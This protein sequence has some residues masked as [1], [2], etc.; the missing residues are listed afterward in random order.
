MRSLV[1]RGA[2]PNYLEGGSVP[3]LIWA[4][5]ADNVVG[6]KALL[7][8]GADPDL[9]GNGHGRGSGK[10]HGV[11]EDGTIIY[12]GWSATDAA[13]ASGQPEFLRL[14]LQ[15]G[16]DPDSAK[17][18]RSND[19]PLLQAAYG[20]LLES[21]KIL[22]A[23]GA[24]INVHHDKYGGNTGPELAIAAR[25]RYDI[26]FWLLEH[27]YTHSLQALA[28][29]AEASRVPLDSDQQLWKE[30]LID[31]LQ[32]RGA[33]FPASFLVKRGLQ[34]R[35]ISTVNVQDLVYGRKSVFDFPLRATERK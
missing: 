19:R 30:K 10:R 29:T 24:D 8:A 12:E 6:F 22:V 1:Q 15:H 7:E 17:G 21:V 9:S 26:A 2:N 35:E 5:C 4:I 34:E 20:G 14:A 31:A 25:G 11:I 28:G 32:K 27:G 18:K 16:G 23:A 33:D 3:S 13:A